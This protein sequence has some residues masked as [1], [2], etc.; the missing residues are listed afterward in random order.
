L[1]LRLNTSI[2]YIIVIHFWNAMQSDTD[3][4]A[5]QYRL[6]LRRKSNW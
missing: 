3:L 4:R 2:A 6:S 5:T 1:A